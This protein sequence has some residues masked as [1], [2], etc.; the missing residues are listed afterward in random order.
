MKGDEKLPSKRA[1][2][3]RDEI[4]SIRC[5]WNLKDYISKHGQRG[6]S[7]EEVLWRLGCY[8]R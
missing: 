4:T 5:T 2:K 3:G 7:D 1:G 8:R 6:E